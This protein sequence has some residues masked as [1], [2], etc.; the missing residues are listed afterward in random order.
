MT[1]EQQKLYDLV[2]ASYKRHGF[3]LVEEP[4]GRVYTCVV[5]NVSSQNYEAPDADIEIRID[6]EIPYVHTAWGAI[7]NDIFNG[8]EKLGYKVVKQSYFYDYYFIYLVRK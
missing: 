8:F 3:D 5:E 6:S 2:K 7:F 4:Q 1:L